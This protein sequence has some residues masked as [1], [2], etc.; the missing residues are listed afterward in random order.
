MLRCGPRGGRAVREWGGVLS[1][2]GGGSIRTHPERI[3]TYPDALAR[4]CQDTRILT[5]PDVNP[6]GI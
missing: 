2:L 6:E 4:F 3:L 5:Y 1:D